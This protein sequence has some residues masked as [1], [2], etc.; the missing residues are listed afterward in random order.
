MVLFQ[1]FLTAMPLGTCWSL[2]RCYLESPSMVCPGI[3]PEPLSMPTAA[4]PDPAVSASHMWALTSMW[5][6]T[7]DPS[8][9]SPA[10]DTVVVCPAPRVV[11]VRGS[12]AIPGLPTDAG[13]GLLATPSQGLGG[14]LPGPT[15][16]PGSWVWDIAGPWEHL[17]VSELAGWQCSQ[18]GRGHTE[19]QAGPHV[20]GVDACPMAQQV[21][22][23][24]PSGSGTGLPPG[25]LP[26]V[27]F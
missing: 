24:E 27:R 9:G 10:E 4:N 18:Q 23:T 25:W 2:L 3:W 5:A 7:W 12:T 20:Q 15:P 8:R 17:Q 13:E 1:K 16:G 14:Q 11:R 26:T 21:P 6:L 19:S 22:G